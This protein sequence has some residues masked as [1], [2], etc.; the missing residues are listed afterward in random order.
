MKG[1][2]G[3]GKRCLFFF[4]SPLLLLLLVI[5]AISMLLSFLGMEFNDNSTE[6]SN[7]KWANIH[8]AQSYCCCYYLC[9]EK[10]QLHRKYC[11]IPTFSPQG[12]GCNFEPYSFLA[13]S[14]HVPPSPPLPFVTQVM[15]TDREE[16]KEE[17]CWQ[18]NF[19]SFFSSLLLT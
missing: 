5:R 18:K 17:K 13:P 3:D 14:T 19:I 1:G 2:W 10:C 6:K 7:L 4:L 8:S 16:K 9:K 15:K 12:K 11:T